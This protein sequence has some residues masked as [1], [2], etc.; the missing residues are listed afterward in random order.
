MSGQQP[1]YAGYAATG[2]QQKGSAYAEAETQAQAAQTALYNE[3][4]ASLSDGPT[5]SMATQPAPYDEASPNMGTNTDPDEGPALPRK[6][7]AFDVFSVGHE[8][9]PT[10]VPRA[11]S[12]TAVVESSSGGV[13]RVPMAGADSAPISV[14]RPVKKTHMYIN[15][16]R[17]VAF[18]AFTGDDLPG[19]VSE[20]S[21]IS[22]N[23]RL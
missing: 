9:A 12:E 21:V 10:I 1:S 6:A 8:G 17:G 20:G 4:S 18:E 23:T 11:R 13:Y 14:S 2:S 7:G 5:Y 15:N 16:T 22:Q 3:A 19:H